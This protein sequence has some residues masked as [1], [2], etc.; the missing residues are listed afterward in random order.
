MIVGNS[1]PGV[2]DARHSL[3]QE[4]L[5]AHQQQ[6]TLVQPMATNHANL[7]YFTTSVQ[8]Q[9]CIGIT[10][11][12]YP[13]GSSMSQDQ[14]LSGNS[15]AIAARK[16]CLDNSALFLRL[17]VTMPWQ[18]DSVSA[19]PKSG[20]NV[21][22]TRSSMSETDVSAAASE[23]DLSDFLLSLLI[24]DRP[25]ITEEQVE[26]E[27]AAM[28]DEERAEALTD[29]F[30]SQCAVDTHNNKRA[31]RDLDKSSIDFFVHQMRLELDRIPEN[32]KRALVEAQTKCLADEFSD[33]RLERFLRCEGMNV[34]VR[35]RDD[36]I[37]FF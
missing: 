14:Y 37:V 21:A 13:L 12:M 32:E 30:G 15:D 35:Q 4:P 20:C 33:A 1:E 34:K 17:Q 2:V 26:L 36:C 10:P 5:F 3:V 6:T 8:N 9:S 27:R 24:L 22:T 18:T 19:V 28:T 25:M 16:R 31:R 29:L 23:S 7:S 11:D